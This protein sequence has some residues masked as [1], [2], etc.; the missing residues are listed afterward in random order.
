MDK[1]IAPLIK[2]VGGK[3]QLI[4]E[5]TNRMPSKFGTYY[6][7]F[8]GGGA[9]YFHLCPNNSII[10]DFN[11]QLT[12]MYKQIKRS[13]KNVVDILSDLQSKYNS[14]KYKEDNDAFYYSKRSEY[15][16]CLINNEFS[17]RSAAL[18]I[19]LNKAG[20][21]GLYRVN[22]CGLYNVP[23]AHKKV[24][25]LFD[26]EN[27][28]NVS[29]ALQSSEIKTGDFCEACIDAKK[30]DFV[31]FDSPYYNTF[32]TYQPN[33]FSNKDHKRLYKLFCSLTNKGVYCIATNS[34]CE[35]IKNL[36]KK[37]YIDVVSVKR[38]V[39]CDATKRIGEE[40]IIKNFNEKGVLKI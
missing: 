30:G 12:N 39:N 28:K 23:S 13:V 36:Y 34:N 35:F 11:P 21:N 3:R 14:F 1:K 5:I 32:D 15:N 10:N 40:L 8:F 29:K 33:G 25:N 9:L 4:P 24:L 27:I 18:L 22:Q 26:D 37:F 17:I 19:F 38:M 7:P 2:W 16:D 31:F 6:E 20:F